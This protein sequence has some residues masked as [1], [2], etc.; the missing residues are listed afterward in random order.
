[1]RKYIIVLV[2]LL[3]II[4]IYELR[5]PEKIFQ[6]NHE[7]VNLLQNGDLA[8]IT[9]ESYKSEFVKISDGNDNN[10]SHIGFV[11]KGSDDSIQIVHMSIDTGYIEWENIEDYITKSNIS[12]IDFYRLN[13]IS[14]N[15][16]IYD[17]LS[18]LYKNEMQFDYSFDYKTIDKLYCSELIY[19]VFNKL[20]YNIQLDNNKR[21]I[22]PSEFTK[23]SISH[24]ICLTN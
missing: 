22:Y 16:K 4:K 18:E 8:L 23:K 21:Y 11:V 2:I 6:F 3:L 10:Y 20:D 19:F 17:I 12:N 15:D 5:E 7:L 14:S 13:N 9:G 24:K 1:M